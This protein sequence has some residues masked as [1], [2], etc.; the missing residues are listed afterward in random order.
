MWWSKQTQHAEPSFSPAF[1]STGVMDAPVEALPTQPA[2]PIPSTSTTGVDRDTKQDMACSEDFYLDAVIEGS[3]S[4]NCKRLTIG[5]RAKASADVV[6]RE[7]VVHG[8]LA[9]NL[10]A[11]DRI[12]IRKHASVTGDLTTR[13]ILIEDGAYFKGTLQIERRRVPRPA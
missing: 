10:R 11:A 9:G 13:R 7:V 6:A 3:F 4:L 1:S 12:E 2:K 5:Q 8:E